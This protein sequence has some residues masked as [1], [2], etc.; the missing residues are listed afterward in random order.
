MEKYHE[1]VRFQEG[2][3]VIAQFPS[4][5]SYSWYLLTTTITGAFWVL[6]MVMIGSLFGGIIWMTLDRLDFMAVLTGALAG[7]GIL[8]LLIGLLVSPYSYRK[9]ISGNKVKLT[10]NGLIVFHKPF[11]KSPVIKNHFSFDM[12]DSISRSGRD[13]N[14]RPSV[15]ELLLPSHFFVV[16]YYKEGQLFLSTTRGDGILKLKMKDKVPVDLVNVVR[17][18][19]SFRVPGGI[20]VRYWTSDRKHYETDSVFIDIKAKYHGR[21]L[22][23]VERARS[24]SLERR[25]PSMGSDERDREANIGKFK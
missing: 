4:S 20:G 3:R 12:L 10:D 1:T 2:Q 15:L 14:I 11:Y 13:D 8:V 9:T 7:F 18:G 17:T 16:S 23:L 25:L 6:I 24:S 21:F 5:M 22:E 19:R